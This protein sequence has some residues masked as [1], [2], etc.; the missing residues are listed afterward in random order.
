VPQAKITDSY[1]FKNKTR[2]YSE[3]SGTFCRSGGKH[4][5][6]LVKNQKKKEKEM[7]IEGIQL[8][9]RQIQG[10]QL[11]TPWTGLVL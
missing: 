9:D 11:C 5:F 7:D 4:P 3:N 1:P 8:D 10:L 2:F 6:W